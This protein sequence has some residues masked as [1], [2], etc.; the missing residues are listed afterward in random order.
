MFFAVDTDKLA[1]IERT[2][3]TAMVTEFDLDLSALAL[4][5]TNFAT[6]IDSANDKATWPN[7][8][9]PS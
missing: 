4:D 2:I 3:S 7:A 6:F 1:L 8:A 9:A 5:M